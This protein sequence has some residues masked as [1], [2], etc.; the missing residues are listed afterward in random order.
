MS[1]LSPFHSA[2]LTLL[3]TLVIL[4]FGLWP[5]SP[6]M[7]N[8][9]SWLPAIPAIDFKHSGIVYLD[10]LNTLAPRQLFHDFT[11]NLRVAAHNVDKSG[12]RPLLMMHDGSDS[13]QLA[14]WQWGAS[15]IAMNG[16]DYS[17]RRKLPRVSAFN[18]LTPGRTVT[19]TLCSSDQSTSLYINGELAAENR[20]WQISIP[21]HGEKLRVILGNSAHAK[22]S[23]QGLLYSATM[24][25]RG[26]THKE[27]QNLYAT[28]F[29]PAQALDDTA[30]GSPHLVMS[31]TRNIHG[32]QSEQVTRVPLLLPERMVILKKNV[33]AVPRHYFRLSRNLLIDMVLNF[34]CFIPFGAF[35]LLSLKHSFSTPRYAVRI[36]ALAGCFLLSLGVE[37]GQIWQMTRHSSLLDLIL[38]TGGGFAG[39]FLAE[40]KERTG[41]RKTASDLS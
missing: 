12:F 16:D 27:I 7:K 34:L 13:E 8:H 26:L 1:K 28:P 2:F 40:W 18:I 24:Y 41:V 23:W 29:L 35:L 25:N 32:T 15:I 19:V 38:N 14:V 30:V 31:L 37:T 39:V 6:F 5:K 22:H 33:L 17:F 36:A 21:E 3:M 11:I 20:T 4:Y 9:A 10:D